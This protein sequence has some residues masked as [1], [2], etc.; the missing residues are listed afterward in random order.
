MET[1]SDKLEALFGR[2]VR[3]KFTD[4]SHT[5]GKLT[6]IKASPIVV[7]DGTGCGSKLTV[8]HAIVLDHEDSF[9]HALTSVERI[10]LA[11]KVSETINRIQPVAKA[12]EPA[13]TVKPIKVVKF[14]ASEFAGFETED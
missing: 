8:P 5:T 4:G 7:D 1:A 11:A 10:E 12:P 6:K 13:P 2:I 9:T 14:E 3:V